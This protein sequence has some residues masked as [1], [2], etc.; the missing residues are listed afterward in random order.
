M[1]ETIS[2]LKDRFKEEQGRFDQVE[3]KSAKFFTAVSVLVAGLSALAAL[4]NGILFQ[5]QT[6][7]AVCA[8]VAFAVAAF[9]IACAWGHALS[10]LSIKSYPSLPSSRETAEYLKAV[11]GEAQK[12]HL[13]NCYVDTL[14]ILKTAIDEK[15]KPLDLAYQ[16]ITIG[17]S[18]F[19]LLAVLTIIRELIA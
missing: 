2:Y 17:A 15:S 11:D 9:S 18:A 16:E 12:A 7:L 4:K 13:Y 1:D 10:A 5:I 14:E 8:F 6:P 3:N 19:A